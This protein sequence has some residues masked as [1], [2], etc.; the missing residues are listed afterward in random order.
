MKQLFVGIDPS[1]RSTGLY[2]Y[3]RTGQFPNYTYEQPFYAQLDTKSK[4]FPNSINRCLYIA[5]LIDQL[6]LDNLDQQTKISL[7]VCQGYFV[8][9]QQGVVIQLAELGALIRYKIL[10]QRQY[11]LCIV[12]PKT[13]KKFV[14]GNGNAK[15]QQMMQ[16][17]LQ[18][19]NFKASTDNLADACGMSRFAQF[20][21]QLWSKNIVLSKKQLNGFQQYLTNQ[22]VVKIEERYVV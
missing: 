3:K 14:T 11:P 10:I 5:S 8:G 19:W 13:V 16:T 9:R 6:I 7:I 18:K 12:P 4:D 20:I 17:V 1:L 22:C 2:L 15:K 21:T